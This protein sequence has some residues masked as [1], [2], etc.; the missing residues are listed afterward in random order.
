ME[1]WELLAFFFGIALLYASVGFGG[2]SSYLAVLALY[3][4]DYRTIRSTALLCN[5]VV[6][7]GGTLIYQRAGHAKWRKMIPIVAAGLPMAFLGGT[8]RLSQPL[9]FLILSITLI[10]AALLLVRQSLFPPS[11]DDDTRSTPLLLNIGLGGGI[12][13]L[14]GLVGIGGGIFLSPLLNLLRWDRPSTIAATA[15]FYILVNSLA[16]LAGQLTQ[17]DFDMDWGLTGLLIAAVFLGGQIGSRVGAKW[18][19]ARWIRLG[20]AGLVLFVG[21]RILLDYFRQG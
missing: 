14:A 3:G 16:G 8:I 12:G 4:L 6:V 15:S 11:G 5:L 18:L 1:H 2:G 17:A 7:T 20:T 19:P 21:V 13:F 9:F 10:A